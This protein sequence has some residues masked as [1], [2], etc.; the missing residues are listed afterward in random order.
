MAR[1]GS[2]ASLVAFGLA[3]LAPSVGLAQDGGAYPSK[4]IQMIVPFPPG[5]STD[6][7]A[8]YLGPKLKDALGQPVIIEN[9][10]GA[11]GAIGATYVAK[12]APDGHTLLIASSSVTNAPQLQKTPTFDTTRD[13]APIAI[14]FQHPFLL[15]ASP[16]LPTD[17]VKD[18]FA[19][20]KANPGKLNIASLGGFSDLMSQM[21]KKAAGLDMQVVPYRGAA[22][23][24]VGVIRGD[25]HM[26]LSAF[27]AAQAQVAAGQLRM[28]AVAGLRRSPSIPEVITLHEAGLTGFELINVIGVLAPAATPKFIREKLTATVASIMGSP[29]ARQ[30][31]LS[32]GNDPA[33]DLSAEYYAAYIKKDNEK[34]R[35]VVEDV[36]YQKQ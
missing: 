17:H 29:E 3:L 1:I 19:H 33:E 24:A 21:L 6:L 10:P 9:R 27:T 32:R 16:N 35:K 34:F 2:A 28:M 36:G 14:A 31:L 4:P 18:L 15:V 20:A 7:L 25:S 5:A 11:G 12:A 23:A 22:E 26:T 8:R 13:L 30:F